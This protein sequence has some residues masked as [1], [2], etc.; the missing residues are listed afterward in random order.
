MVFF[1]AGNEHMNVNLE[2]VPFLSYFVEGLV[3]FENIKLL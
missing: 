2:N 3:E 1:L